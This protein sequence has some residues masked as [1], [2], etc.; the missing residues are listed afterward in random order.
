MATMGEWRCA[1]DPASLSR[2]DELIDATI[3]LVIRAPDECGV[4][5]VERKS[6]EFGHDLVVIDDDVAGLRVLCDVG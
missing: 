5:L 1:R 6:A 3:M 4:M 2:G